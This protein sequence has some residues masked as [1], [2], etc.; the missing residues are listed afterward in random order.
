M[1]KQCGWVIALVAAVTFSIESRAAVMYSTPGSTYTQDFDSLP[2][3]PENVSLG[4]SPAG[5][6]DDNASPGVG[7][8]SIVGWYLYHPTSQTEGGFSGR[9]RMRIG[10]GSANT[11]A[12]MSFGSSTST[13]RAMG[14]LNSNTLAPA[15]DNAYI[16]ARFTNSTG[17]TLTE[18]TLSY[19]GEQWRDGGA[20]N[21]VSQSL[22]FGYK[23]TNGA[24]NLQD[25]GF[26][27]EAA[28]NFTSPVFTNT[29]SGAAV[30]GNVA[31]KVAIG[32]VTVTGIS[33]APGDDL[34]IRWADLN[35]AG[36]DHGLAIDDLSFS[37]IPEPASLTLVGM[38]SLGLLIRRRVD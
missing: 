15:N 38:A 20:T 10:A 37:A 30:N 4:A 7:N 36:N 18:F 32:P 17:I 23:I 21:P 16:G 27:G 31:G 2:N 24:A 33:W 25:T 19:S 8:F 6:T 11:G 26:T 28:L 22:T 12:F 14:A 1:C 5:W 3:T 34:W 35:D 13:E 9:Q 29:G